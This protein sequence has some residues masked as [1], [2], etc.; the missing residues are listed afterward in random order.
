MPGSIK[1]LEESSWALWTER[2]GGVT[3]EGV[4]EVQRSLRGQ[5]TR[6][7][8]GVVAEHTTPR[9][10]ATPRKEPHTPNTRLGR[11]SPPLDVGGVHSQGP[12]PSFDPSPYP[13]SGVVQPRGP[14]GPSAIG[15]DEDVPV[16]AREEAARRGRRL[17]GI[18]TRRGRRQEG[19]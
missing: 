19:R 2:R 18:H 17:G 4:K 13:G 5:G 14:G 16:V 15:T 11:H 3:N 1:G 10:G 12:H 7:K 6:E 8:G 9:T